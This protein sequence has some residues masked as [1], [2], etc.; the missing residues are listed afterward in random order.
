MNNNDHKSKNALQGTMPWLLILILGGLAFLFYNLVIDVGR[1]QA[2]GTVTLLFFDRNGTALTTSQVRSLSNN[3]GS[4]YNNDFLVNPTNLRAISSGP[5][6]TSGSNLAFNIPSQAVALAFNWPT[7][8]NG[9]SLIILDNGGIG[10]TAGATVNFCYQAA[11]DTKK[12][13]DAALAA[14]AD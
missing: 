11:R 5:L 1:A 13:L 9:Y 14:R 3:G 12:K 7:L 2:G 4:G 6:F 10:F 8:P